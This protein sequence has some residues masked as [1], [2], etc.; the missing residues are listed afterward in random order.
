MALITYPLNNVEYNAEDAELFHAVRT[1]GVFTSDDFL[2]SA[3]ANSRAVT[4]NPGIAWIAN[5]KFSGKAVAMKEDFSLTMPLSGSFLPRIDAVVIRFDAN[6]NTTD[7]VYKTGTEASSP[8]APEVVRTESVY[9]LHLCHVYRKAG[10]ASIG[11]ADITDLRANPDYCGFVSDEMSGYVLPL[12]GGSMRGNIDMNGN[13]ITGLSAPTDDSDAV[14]KHYAD[15]I[16]EKIISVGAK[17]ETWE[18][19]I[20][21]NSAAEHE[22]SGNVQAVIVG[23]RKINGSEAISATWSLNM[24]G[25]AQNCYGKL[26]DSVVAWKTTVTISGNRVRV[27]RN[28]TSDLKYYVTAILPSS[29]TL[30]VTDDGEGNVVIS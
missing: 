8:A 27:S 15:R 28:G 30:S 17:L 24:S 26:G 7:I 10:S 23:L 29:D 12:N 14:N 2:V 13:K 21:G 22:F 5:T 9:E 1:S 20:E 18:T 6:A 19:T 4:I 11:S 25:L 3:V 16:A